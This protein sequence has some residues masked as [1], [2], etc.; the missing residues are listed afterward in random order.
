MKILAIETSSATSSIAVAENG[1]IMDV[2]RFV[3]PR[4]RGAE[5]F[6]L[7]EEMRPAWSGMERMAI[8]VGP[9]SYNGLR[10]ACTLAGSFQMTLGIEI[11][12]SPSCCLLDVEESDYIALGDAR[13]GRIWVASIRSRRLQGEMSLLTC[14]EAGDFVRNASLTAYAVGTVQG[15]EHLPPATPDAA[16]LANLAPALPTADPAKIEPLYLKPP[17]I[18]APREARP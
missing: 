2:R 12:T 3:A 6:T 18:T 15:F 5:I 13:G 14:A 7:L 1:Q 17:H 4:G 9:G 16:V 8:G 10:T 11:V